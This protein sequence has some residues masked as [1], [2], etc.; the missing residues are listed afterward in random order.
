MSRLPIR[1]RLALAFAVVMALVLGATGAFVYARTADDV[2]RQIDRELSARLAGV[3]AIVRDDGDDLGDPEMD[4]LGRVDA[5]GAVQVLGPR[6]E[7][8][9]ATSDQ[10][11]GGPLLSGER[12]DALVE[13]GETD[14]RLEPSGETLRLVGDRAGD[15]GVQYTILV[16]ASLA[17]RE[18]ALASL[19]RLLAIGGPIALLLASLAS[20]GV[21]TAALRPVDS[22]RRRAAAIGAADPEARLPVPP[23]GDELARLGETLNEMLERLDRA[24][25]R[26]RWFVADAS[27][28]LRTPLAILKAEIELALEAGR[29]PEELRRAL[30]SAAEETDRLTQLAED[31]LVLARSA[32]GGLPL[33]IE[34]V[35]LRALVERVRSRFGRHEGAIE[36]ISIELPPG[37]R[38]EADRAHVERAIANLID[39]ALRHGAGRIRVTGAVAGDRVE[40][41]VADEGEGLSDDLLETAFERFSRADAARSGGGTG[42]GLAIVETIARAHGGAAGIANRPR[43]GADA[44]ISLPRDRP[45]SRGQPAGDEALIDV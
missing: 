45:R 42:L 2:D 11:L 7:V 20:Y 39:N 41:H 38:V 24:L 36:R 23:S 37:L 6:G 9:D 22:M 5:E 27:H 32:E 19:S 8:V 43:G 35:D 26:E 10:L 34:P 16:G 30:G 18:Q 33:D 40:V 15:D 13:G 29:S 3:I 4:P 28:E 1:L 21:A 25:A 14:L 17:E 31:L 12:L 44:W